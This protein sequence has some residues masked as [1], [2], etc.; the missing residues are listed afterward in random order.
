MPR[1]ISKEQFLEHTW[2]S[3]SEHRYGRNYTNKILC[4][5]DLPSQSDLLPVIAAL[6]FYLH[7]FCRSTLAWKHWFNLCYSVDKA[8]VAN[9]IFY[10]LFLIF[11]YIK[12]RCLCFFLFCFFFPASFP[13]FLFLRLTKSL[14]YLIAYSI[15]DFN[16]YV[17]WK[18]FHPY[19]DIHLVF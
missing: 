10:S 2:Q 4:S 14:N 15:M 3:G 5:L 13:A 8:I 11:L 16:D 17:F 18:C 1:E 12:Y 19:C 6:L 9:F 7:T